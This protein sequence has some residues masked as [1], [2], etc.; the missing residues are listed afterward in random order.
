MLTNIL[1]SVNTL[2]KKQ[3]NDLSTVNTVTNAPQIQWIVD[4]SFPE[5]IQN[6]WTT[7]P[8]IAEQRIRTRTEDVEIHVMNTALSPQGNNVPK[9]IS[10]M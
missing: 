2:D 6:V 3:I 10:R 7:N 5:S 4:N 9:A 1:S 8:R